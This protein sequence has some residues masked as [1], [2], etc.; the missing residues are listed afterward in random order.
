[1]IK[2]LPSNRLHGADVLNNDDLAVHAREFVL[3][4]SLNRI[5]QI[6]SPRY[7]SCPVSIKEAVAGILSTLP[8]QSAEVVL[9][10][11]SDWTGTLGDLVSLGVVLDD[12]H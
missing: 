11:S 2:Y 5:R 12:N 8:L 1:M 3:S 9:N 6:L 7:G 4:C 10:L